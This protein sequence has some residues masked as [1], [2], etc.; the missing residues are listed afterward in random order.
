VKKIRAQGGRNAL[1]GNLQQ[2][3][4]EIHDKTEATAK[5]VVKKSYRRKEK[6]LL[7]Q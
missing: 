5:D 4:E 6:G 3:E 7:G 1:I 2:E